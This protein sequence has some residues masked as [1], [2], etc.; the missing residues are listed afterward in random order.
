VLL[1]AL[2]CPMVLVKVLGLVLVLV[3]SKVVQ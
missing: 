1:D 3:D 2:L